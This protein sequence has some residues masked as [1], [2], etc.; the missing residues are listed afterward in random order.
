MEKYEVRAWYERAARYGAP[1]VGAAVILAGCTSVLA[2]SG[3]VG[4]GA[5]A[6]AGGSNSETYSGSGESESLCTID[7][8]AV[9]GK[10]LAVTL[11]LPSI[12]PQLLS[13]NASGDFQVT[14]N[15]LA[16]GLS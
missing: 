13:N 6:P 9:G 12:S 4:Y 16:E 1:A 2:P 10:M 5:E 7:I 11:K 15:S 8:K 14:A 3:N